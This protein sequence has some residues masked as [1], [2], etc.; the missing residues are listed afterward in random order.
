MT[1]QMP[2]AHPK[3]NVARAIGRNT[4]SGLN[5]VTI[6]RMITKNFAPSGASL[7]FDVPTRCR[8]S[9]GSKATL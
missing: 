1:F 7:I 6:F 4:R 3:T 5:S 9:I 8:A 2:Y